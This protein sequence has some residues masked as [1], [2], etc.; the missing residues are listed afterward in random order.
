M[1]KITIMTLHRLFYYYFDFM[2]FNVERENVSDKNTLWFTLCEYCDW[3]IHKDFSGVNFASAALSFSNWRLVQRSAFD[4]YHSHSRS[5]IY[6]SSLR[7]DAHSINCVLIF[8]SFYILREISMECELGQK[9][10]QPLADTILFPFQ[11]TLNLDVCT[12]LLLV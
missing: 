10:T 8:G 5:S 2:F 4:W 3:K 1:S 12:Y 11:S 7:D 9:N 6:T